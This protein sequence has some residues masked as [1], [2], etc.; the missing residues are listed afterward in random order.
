MSAA[1][2]YTSHG[3]N[4]PLALVREG[5]QLLRSHHAGGV[6]SRVEIALGRLAALERVVVETT[7]V[8]LEGLRMLDLGAGQRLVGMHYF[9][10]RGNEVVGIDLDVVAQGLDP[11]AY[12]RM[13]RTNGGKRTVKTLARKALLVDARG[14]RELARQLGL[15]CV[16]RLDVSRQ[17]ASCTSFPDA[18]FDA[19]YSTSVFSHLRD[20]AAVLAETVRLLRP[21]GVAWHD[22]LLYT[23][24]TGCMDLRLL[25]GG[26]ADLPLWAHLRPAHRGEVAPSAYLNE[27][28]LP[29]WRSLFDRHLPGARVVLGQYEREQLE[30]Q[31]RGLQAAGELAGYG[32][33]EL[34]TADVTVVWRKPHLTLE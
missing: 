26:H 30:L 19:V 23:S 6:A 14:R 5:R 15:E 17:D 24:R 9:R 31:A 33:D 18:S 3:G 28:R 11:A 32:L 21:G 8:S 20:P 25:A 34:L 7:G 12:W 4:G 22:F 10:A 29:E 27:V 13:L 16:P 1:G 2:S